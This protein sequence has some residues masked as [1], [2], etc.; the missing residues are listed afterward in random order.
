MFSLIL[1]PNCV[2]GLIKYGRWQARRH[3]SRC[4]YYFIKSL[5]DMFD[6]IVVGFA[7]IDCDST[8]TFLHLDPATRGRI[9]E[10]VISVYDVSLVRAAY[11]ENVLEFAQRRVIFTG[12]VI[13]SV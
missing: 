3:L 4:I 7:L 9:P 6:A 8:E 10:T 12:G 1:R 13:S 5:S 11:N 2:A